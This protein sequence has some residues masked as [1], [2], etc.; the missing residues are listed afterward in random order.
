M[1]YKQIVEWAQYWTRGVTTRYTFYIW[2]CLIE[3]NTLTS[4]CEIN[5]NPQYFNHIYFA[6]VNY[7]SVSDTLKT[8]TSFGTYLNRKHDDGYLR[9]HTA[10]V[11]HGA[12][13]LNGCWLRCVV[14]WPCEATMN[15]LAYTYMHACMHTCMHT[16]IFI[17]GFA[18]AQG[19]VLFVIFAWIC[20][21]G[22]ESQVRNSYV[23]KC[24]CLFDCNWH[25]GKIKWE[26]KIDIL[27]WRDR[28]SNFRP[29]VSRAGD[30]SFTLHLIQLIQWFPNNSI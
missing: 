18:L 23:L 10:T 16:Y 2:H 4:I 8:L 24:D 9:G 26:T 7:W 3:D 25:I 29:L 14:S 19:T 15:Q 21:D 6:R 11:R 17:Q 12:T 1:N 30:L 20:C 5:L 22:F 13:V 28:G 27:G